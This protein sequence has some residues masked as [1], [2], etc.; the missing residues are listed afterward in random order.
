[1]RAAPR[2]ALERCILEFLH[3]R[4]LPDEEVLRLLPEPT[5]PDEALVEADINGLPLKL[6]AVALGAALTQADKIRLLCASR[7]WKDSVRQTAMWRVLSFR[8]LTRGSLGTSTLLARLTHP[9]FGKLTSLA[10]P[11]ILVGKGTAQKLRRLC[12]QIVEFDLVACRGLNSVAILSSFVDNFPL[13]ECLR[14]SSYWLCPASLRLLLAG[15]PSLQVLEVKNA[16]DLMKMNVDV[17]EYFPEHT[18]LRVLSLD[19]GCFAG[20]RW[21]HR[22]AGTH[23]LKS[24][25][26][27]LPSLERLCLNRWSELTEDNVHEIVNRCPGLNELRLAGISVGAGDPRVTRDEEWRLEQ[28]AGV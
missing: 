19:M 14:L 8:R 2:Q 6:P 9:S 24:L 27:K 21:Q 7:A 22:G 13:L 16:V 11:D 26:P 1:V 5:K 12:P 18:A 17:T 23:L 28:V 20:P 15:L 3:H 25:V 10:L 4:G